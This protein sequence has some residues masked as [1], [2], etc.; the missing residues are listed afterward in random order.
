VA[1]STAIRVRQDLRREGLAYI[2][3]ND[4]TQLNET[5]LQSPIVK[6]LHEAAL[7]V[8]IERT[9]AQNGDLI[10]SVPTRPRSSTMRSAR[11]AARSATKGL[12]QRQG[13]GAAVGSGLPDVRI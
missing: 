7:K 4:V 9:G 1:K 12:R 2:K 13:V 11:C 10:S 6:N 8:I 3:V 5:G